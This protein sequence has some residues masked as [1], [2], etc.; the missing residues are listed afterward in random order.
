L[1][2][3]LVGL[4]SIVA[5]VVLLRELSAAFYGV[6]LIYLLA[7]GAWLLWT[8]GGALLGSGPRAEARGLRPS[9]VR[10]RALL[11]A[12]GVVVPLEVALIRGL[13]LL[14]GGIPGAYLALPAQIGASALCL[15]PPSV[16]LGLLFQWT[17]RRYLPEMRSGLIPDPA[18]RADNA[19]P[20]V[21]S[22]LTDV[23][24][25]R[26]VAPTSGRRSLA[27][28]YAIESAGGVAGGLA[29]TW[30]L[31]ARLPGATLALATAAVAFT[32]ALLA[33]ERPGARV[34]HAPRV[35]ARPAPGVGAR[36]AV[37]LQ[38]RAVRLVA[39]AGILACLVAAWHAHRLDR[40]MTS[41]NHPDVV[42]SLDS[43]YGRV[44]ITERAGQ[45]S[46]YENDA[47]VFES[48]GTGPE[49]FAHL[50][51]LQ[52]EAPRRVLVLGGAGA[53]LLGEVAR[54]DPERIDDVELDA[55]VVDLMARHLP[56]A[57]RGSLSLPTVRMTFGDPRRAIA[58][59]GRPA[60]RVRPVTGPGPAESPTATDGLDCADGYDAI[61]V[62]AAEPASAQANRFF[63]REFF[64]QC[65]TRVRP[66]GIVSLRLPSMENAWTPPLISRTASIYTALHE[67]FADVVVLPGSSNIVLASATRL[68][69]DPQVL[70]ERL[71]ARGIRAR[72]VTA[73]YVHYLYSNDRYAEIEAVLARSRAR[74][75]TDANAASYQATT[76]LWLSKFFPSIAQVDL[77]WV[78][79]AYGW[80]APRSWLLL[81]VAAGLALLWRWRGW[82][83]RTV[84]M[85]SV[86]F[87]GMTLETL[88]LLQY[89][90]KQGVMFQDLGVLLMSVMAGLA[91]GAW[92]VDGMVK[93]GLKSCSTTEVPVAQGFSPVF[94]LVA[95]VLLA[96]VASVAIAGGYG[97][98]L[99]PIAA[100]LFVTGG[101]VAGVF[102]CA[103]VG[104]DRR[105]LRGGER[106]GA[107]IDQRRLV[108]P[109]YGAD[110]LGGCAGSIAC[111][112]VFIPLL[113][114]P[115][116]AQWAA[117][118]AAVALLL[119]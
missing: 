57:F 55:G 103:S 67:V 39:L 11:V 93:A 66:G 61:I 102:A 107:R 104:D 84:L 119:A 58:N 9:S 32:G 77:A 101:I 74:S 12:V 68:V 44:T 81:G 2:I 47:L 70:A 112:M 59:C 10:V 43:P 20:E 115:L 3:F 34:R 82:S 48:E 110:V 27:R 62:A 99:L 23:G 90:L 51:L 50:S 79:G 42:D 60:K 109:L 14:L 26:R 45:V 54:H 28:A 46:A 118:L 83:R 1:H 111:S 41:W 78:S 73:R 94:F 49:E 72:L 100:M 92:G 75:N 31:H 69:R 85:A 88:L 87:V 16:L 116:T 35:G 33:M 56:P 95:L 97:S 114:L 53:G 106:A 7:L 117:A 21:R 22:D 65:A 91:A 38:D 71:A 19:E 80:R 17:A 96:L 98:G 113:G 89:Q 63:T 86:A 105:V 108:S 29:S 8:A 52:H 5:Q 24:A 76:I 15:L 37:P 18:T 6:D 36:R 13:R 40:W 30:A 4:L 64:A 25:T